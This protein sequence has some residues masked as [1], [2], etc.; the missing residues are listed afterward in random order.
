MTTELSAKAK[1]ST[2]RIAEHV[3][4]GRE[5]TSDQALQLT[6]PEFKNVY[7]EMVHQLGNR[8]PYV[9][10]LFFVDEVLA[11]FPQYSLQQF[12]VPQQRGKFLTP[13]DFD[14]IIHRQVYGLQK[15]PPSF[16]KFIV[17]EFRLYWKW[18]SL[19]FIISF[20]GLHFS[21]A[22]NTYSVLSGLL[23]QSAT[24]FVS[25]FLIFTVTQS[26]LIQQDLTLFRQGLLHRY[27]R[28]DRNVAILGILVIGSVIFN[29]MFV[30]LPY[31][32]K[33]FIEGYKLDLYNFW[34]AIST[35]IVITLLI[36][37]FISVV[38]YYLERSQDVVDRDLARKILAAERDF[39]LDKDQKNP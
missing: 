11:T 34:G 32:L 15:E 2:L 30:N 33:V 31:E 12:R 37:A 3:V 17:G 7:I 18:L 5:V 8:N 24:V 4:S 38:G 19:V 28:D 14:F 25:I 26:A 27:R 23:I 35:S 36:D 39:I 1:E 29:N 21:G 20:I 9:V 6:L 22:Q 13:S 10:L 16:W